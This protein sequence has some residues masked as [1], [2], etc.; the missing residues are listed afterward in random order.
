LCKANCKNTKGDASQ[1]RG[2]TFEKTTT[3]SK[4]QPIKQ[5]KHVLD[6]QNDNNAT[7]IENANILGRVFGGSEEEHT[8]ISETG[9]IK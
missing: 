1:I 2:Q 3:Q 9:R 7:T 4:N 6:K 8:L 5:R